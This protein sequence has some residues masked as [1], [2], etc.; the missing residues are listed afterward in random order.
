MII[1]L[2]TTLEHCKEP[3][4]RT[5]KKVVLL[6]LAIFLISFTRVT[7]QEYSAAGYW[8]MG[9]DTA[10]LRL[11]ERQA[12]GEAL[13]PD[14]QT[15][16]TG[17]RIKLA[18]YFDRMSDSEK[19]DYYKYR[20]EWASQPQAEAWAPS[21]RET[22]VYTGEKSMYTQ[23]L[24][25][26]GLFGALYGGA[27][28]AIFGLEDNGGLAAGLPL[29]SAGASVLIPVLTMKDK[30]VSNNSLALS[31]HGKAIG[32]MQGAALGFL[33]SGDN[34]DEGKLILA[35]SAV[36]SIGL[37]RLG[38]ALGKN[39]QWSQGQAALYSYYGT[40]MPFEGLALVAAFSSEDPRMYAFGSLAFGAGGYLIADRIGQKFDF[41]KGDVTAT[42]ALATMNGLLGLMIIADVNSDNMDPSPAQFLVPAAGALGGTIAGHFWLKDAKLTNQQGRNVALAS[43]G[44]SLIGLGLAALFTPES[45][46]PYYVT[47][48]I[49]GMTSYA[50]LVSMYKKNNIQTYTDNSNKSQWDINV[51]P[52]NIFFNRK[53]AGYANA[54]PGKRITFLP[55]F[56]ATLNF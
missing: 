52:Q 2:F 48:F 36:S 5:M 44:G 39:Q 20:S 3:N 32:A 54:N 6:S 16:L 15:F 22:E 43:S 13:T 53:I 38:Y 1:D 37:G 4:S 18:E 27:A 28:I 11:I 17:Y 33:I 47:S 7:A 9:N 56:S 45:A 23:Y 14:D 31:I 25:S 41:T 49:T 40:L 42:G 55:A 30:Y 26:S 19:S 21:R 10:Y 51:M 29:L 46:A 24:V 35:L 50:I 12:A 8:R 34:L